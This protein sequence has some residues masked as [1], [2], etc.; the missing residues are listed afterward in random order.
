[1]L[2]KMG[3]LSIRNSALDCLVDRS[4]SFLSQSPQA[5]IRSQ[6]DCW[7]EANTETLLQLAGFLRDEIRKHQVLVGKRELKISGLFFFWWPHHEPCGILIP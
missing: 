6:T 5:N 7:D 1:M 4:G 2:G 3:R